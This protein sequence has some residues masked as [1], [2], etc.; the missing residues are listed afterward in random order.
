[1][2][3]N[4]SLKNGRRTDPSPQN[5]LFFFSSQLD[6]ELKKNK[7]TNRSIFFILRLCNKFS[8][9]KPVKSTHTFLHNLWEDSFCVLRRIPPT[10][11]VLILFESSSPFLVDVISMGG[12]F[13]QILP[14]FFYIHRNLKNDHFHISSIQPF[15]LTLKKKFQIMIE[16]LVKSLEL[17]IVFGVR[18][19][20]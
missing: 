11:F 12:L 1:M 2:K 6:S 8:F 10:H 19:F 7:Q 9:D 3:F 5:F 16:N 15:F 14:P 4:P 13:F 18:L 17:S 20:F